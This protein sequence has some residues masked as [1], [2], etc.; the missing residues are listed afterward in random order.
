MSHRYKRREFVRAV[1]YGLAGWTLVPLG[2]QARRR[3][4]LGAET[5]AGGL[6]PRTIGTRTLGGDFRFD[7]VGLRVEKE[8]AVVWL[9]MGDFH[10]A[11]AFHPANAHLIAGPV[12]LRIPAEAQPWHSG[13]LGLDAGTQFRHRFTVAGVYD[14]F[15][16]PHYA[17]GMVGRIV[18]GEASA[19]SARPLAELNE[20]S[21]K[22]M[23]SVEAIVGPRGRTF[24]W[25]ARINGVLLLAANDRE[26]ATAAE[27]V[28]K[29]ATGDETLGQLLADA[30]LA[31][32]FGRKLAG[33][34]TNVSNDV[35]YEELVSRADELKEMLAA[36]RGDVS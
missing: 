15:C 25:A 2:L 17:F 29:A 3:G 36:A 31:S 4:A 1:S 34:A 35:D 27:S 5:I 16:Q 14:Y 7:P 11:T 13:M 22:Q 33:F 26:A 8:E 10:T 9:N 6:P 20:A 32:E 18:V 21:R 23:P 12:A 30:A 24:E 28:R 19:E